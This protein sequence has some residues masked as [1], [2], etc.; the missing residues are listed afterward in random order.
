TY[1]FID[2]TRYGSESYFHETYLAVETGSRVLLKDLLFDD[3]YGS[4]EDELYARDVTGDGKDEIILQQLIGMTGGYGQYLSRIF[5][6][7]SGEIKEIFC[8][9]TVNGYNFNT[10]FSSRLKD[11]LML[12]ISNKFTGYSISLDLSNRKEYYVN[13]YDE[14]GKLI[15]DDKYDQIMIDSFFEFVP[16][17]SDKDG[18]FE[19]KCAQYVSLIGH[20]DHIG[21][22]ESIIKYNPDTR[23]F[24][25]I[26]SE[27][28]INTESNLL[29][30]F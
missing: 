19:I 14:T 2:N 8:S 17:D 11:G 24:E 26:K 12:E 10:G 9:Y 5:E 22:A 21:D 28:K 29:V 25:V 16:Q 13:H 4:Y 23:A 20:A 3:W 15:L 1:L 27:F 7:I 18:I 6:V 30:V